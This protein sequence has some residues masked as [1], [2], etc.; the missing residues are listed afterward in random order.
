MGAADCHTQ[1]TEARGFR[2]Q[3]DWLPL[4]SIN[5]QDGNIVIWIGADHFADQGR[6]ANRL[7]GDW[8]NHAI[9]DMEIGDNDLIAVNPAR[10]GTAVGEVFAVGR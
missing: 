7:D 4:E 6:R 2:L 5:A 9:D 3:G 10:T 8:I 1:L